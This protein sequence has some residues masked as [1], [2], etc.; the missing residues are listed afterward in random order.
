MIAFGIEKRFVY[1][2]LFPRTG[3]TESNVMEPKNLLS[4]TRCSSGQKRCLQSVHHPGT[5]TYSSF[6]PKLISSNPT[7]H[8]HVRYFTSRLE[9]SNG[10]FSVTRIPILELNHI[11]YNP[12]T[13]RT[14]ELDISHRSNTTISL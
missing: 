8:I 2:T 4:C 14:T 12:Q 11:T 10:L 6:Y 13:D 9:V 3:S 7:A 5:L 1:S